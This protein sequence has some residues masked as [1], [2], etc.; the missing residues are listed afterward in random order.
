MLLKTLLNKVEHFKC[1]VFKTV[2]R[3]WVNRVD[4]LIITIEPRRNSR[5]VCSLCGQS[6]STYDTSRSGRLFEYVP[7]WAF[8]VYFS[9]RM[10]RVSCPIDGVTVE[11]VPWADGKQ[12]QTTTYQVFLARWARR[13]S[14]K[15]TADVFR[16]TWDNVH[17]AVQRVVEYGLSKKDWS[18]ITQIGIDEIAVFKGHKYLT[19]VYQL[20]AG[21]RRLLWVG[22]NRTKKT[23]GEFFKELGKERAALLEYVVTDM[24]PAYLNVVKAKAIN[25]LQILD[26]FHIMK[27]FNEAIDLVRRQEARRLTKKHGK[28]HVLVG[29]R[30]LL[31]KRVK[32]LTRRQ[33]RSLRE[34][35]GLN[36]KSIKA[37]LL[38]EDFQQF[39]ECQNVR[40]ASYFIDDWI[41]RVKRTSILPMKK[42]AKMLQSHRSLILCWF[43]AREEGLALGAVEGF[44][45]RSKLTIRKAF[46]FRSEEAVI[47]Q[48]YHVL[49]KLPEPKIT[50][51]F[52]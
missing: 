17:R 18:G 46:G 1:F 12:E 49:G 29:A 15:E 37:Y 45:N 10:R 26:R 41:R 22:R 6:A 50:H 51:R 48:L 52:C 34:L 9:Y 28:G 43:Y 39:W 3:T 30:W 40:E 13:L 19:V 33:G 32:N 7:I 27:K 5:G 35:L 42:V 23:L 8:K 25:A 11:R 16:T 36:L 24:W 14:W 21:C 44:N 20:N 4:A 2:E 31:L 47:L 38:R